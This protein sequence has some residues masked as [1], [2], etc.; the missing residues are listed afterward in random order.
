MAHPAELIT[1]LRAASQD[2][3][4]VY[5]RLQQ[6]L[7]RYNTLGGQTFLAAFFADPANSSYDLTE[8][9]IVSI[10]VSIGNLV[11]FWTAGNGTNFSRALP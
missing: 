6:L 10:V 5:T 4:G 1:D 8:D 3:E 11:T 9:Q 2:L 7:T